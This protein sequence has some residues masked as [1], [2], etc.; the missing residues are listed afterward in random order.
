MDMGMG[1]SG[2][3]EQS[4]V[5]RRT[6]PP[7]S[8]PTKTMMTAGHRC[9]SSAAPAA[10]AAAVTGKTQSQPQPQSQSQ[11]SQPQSRWGAPLVVRSHGCGC[12]PLHNI[13]TA[14]TSASMRM[15]MSMAV[16]RNV[17]TAQGGAAK[18][19]SPPSSL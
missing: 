6:E 10:P 16:Y 12:P 4:A 9:H 11:Q 3:Q 1:G 5:V 18:R 8:A 19:T 13:P 15:S 7:V 2:A 17:Y 14:A